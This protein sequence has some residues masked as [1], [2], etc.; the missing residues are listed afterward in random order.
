MVEPQDSN[1]MLL[2]VSWLILVVDGIVVGQ[3]ERVYDP[4][5]PLCLAFRAL[6]DGKS[7]LICRI[8]E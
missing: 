2:S 6:D 4:M 5:C 3:P 8:R 1:A 7:L